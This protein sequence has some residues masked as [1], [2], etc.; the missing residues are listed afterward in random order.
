MDYKKTMH[1]RRL[2]ARNVNHNHPDEMLRNNAGTQPHYI[3]FVTSD[4]TLEYFLSSLIGY[5][6]WKNHPVFHGAITPSSSLM[7]EI[8]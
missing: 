2:T 8:V 4:L 3:F 7:L 5:Q 1:Y 6:N